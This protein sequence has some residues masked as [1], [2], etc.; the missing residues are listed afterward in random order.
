M[1]DEKRRNEVQEEGLIRYQFLGQTD[2]V[3]TYFLPEEIQLEIIHDDKDAILF[4]DRPTEK[5]I[6]EACAED[7][8]YNY[9]IDNEYE[10]LNE[11]TEEVQLEEV[12]KNEMVIKYIENPSEKVQLAALDK[13][14]RSVRYI[15]NPTEQVQEL[16]ISYDLS[17]LSD[18]RFVT[19]IEKT[20]EILKEKLSNPRVRKQYVIDFLQCTFLIGDKLEFINRYGSK[21]AKRLG[22]EL[23]LSGLYMVIKEGDIMY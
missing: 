21:K 12:S 15:R 17:T 16:A 18:L 5:V 9:M 6:R 11:A 8:Y 19:P 2:C 13:W 20:I 3:F 1:Q 7:L 4:I 23:D 22:M 10:Y 14:Y